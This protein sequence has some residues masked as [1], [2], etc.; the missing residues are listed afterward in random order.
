MSAQEPRILYIG[1]TVIWTR[2]DL[3]SDYPT[4]DWTLTYH[5]VG[6]TTAFTKAAAESGNDYVMTLL[7]A[8]TAA[9]DAGFY[10][11]QAWIAH[12]SDGRKYMIDQGRAELQAALDGAVPADQRSHARKMVDALEAMMEGKA[13]LDQIKY[14]LPDGRSLDRVPASEFLKLLTHYR[15]EVAT[16]EAAE[17][18]ADGLGTD[19]T[20]IDVEFP[21]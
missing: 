8:D 19:R 11:W 18:M 10:R 17:D 5:F 4:A 9:M 2:S 3:Y 15:A 13:S 16:E 20:I 14:A 12:D 6:A 21:D 1:T 7:P